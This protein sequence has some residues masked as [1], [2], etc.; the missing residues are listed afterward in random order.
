MPTGRIAT[1]AV[2]TPQSNPSSELSRNTS[3][4]IKNPERNG[5][6]GDFDHRGRPAGTAYG[7]AEQVDTGPQPDS[8]QG[9]VRAPSS[10][11][12]RN[13]STAQKTLSVI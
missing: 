12:L 8:V 3:F 4:P 13:P 9:R 5:A 7:G 11:D 6:G 10:S 1:T 2:F